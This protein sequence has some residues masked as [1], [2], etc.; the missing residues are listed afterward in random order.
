MLKVHTCIDVHPF[1]AYTHIVCHA[2]HGSAERGAVR[3]YTHFLGVYAQAVDVM[4]H[5][6]RC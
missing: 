1:E 3:I 5:A 6:E 4:L 2:A